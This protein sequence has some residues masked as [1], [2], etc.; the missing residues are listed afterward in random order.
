MN[1]ILKKMGKIEEN[2]GNIEENLA[3]IVCY[4]L[5]FTGNL[6]D[7]EQKIW[8]S[9]DAAAHRCAGCDWLPA[10]SGDNLPTRQ[11]RVP[12][13]STAANLATPRSAARRPTQV[14]QHC[15]AL[16]TGC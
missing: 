13:S 3:I 1:K 2:K 4:D 9:N 15:S 5:N 10:I 8:L 7:E 11:C 6:R 14:W 16:E 12:A